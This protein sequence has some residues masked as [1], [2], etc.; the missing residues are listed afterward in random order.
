M[1]QYEGGKMKKE[2][3]KN[4]KTKKEKRVKETK[5]GYFKEVGLELKKVTFPTFK[6][7]MK[8]TFATVIFC[9]VLVLFFILLNLLLSG[10]KGMF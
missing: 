5:N 8:Y 3:P 4:V 2:S 1:E 9:G 10:I 7:V 6:S